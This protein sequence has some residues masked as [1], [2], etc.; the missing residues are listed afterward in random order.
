MTGLPNQLLDRV[1]SVLQVLPPL[2]SA[3]RYHDDYLDEMHSLRD[4]AD[5]KCWP[6]HCD[7]QTSMLDFRRL[8][9]P[10]RHL[11][12]H[13]IVDFLGKSDVT[14]VTILFSSMSRSIEKL[15]DELLL[16]CIILTPPKFRSYWMEK[17][18]PALSSVEA[19]ALK[20]MLRSFCTLHIGSWQIGLENYIAQLPVVKSD[21]YRT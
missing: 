14:Y 6:I 13:L 10:F 4:L 8:S 11:F 16:N 19:N 5:E 9:E 2:P 21:V 7:G 12:K 15:G 18:S 1:G 3:L 17:I 20:S